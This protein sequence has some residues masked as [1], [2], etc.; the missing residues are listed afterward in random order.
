MSI[1]TKRKKHEIIVISSDEDG[2][3]WRHAPKCQRPNPG[4]NPVSWAPSTAT[5]PPVGQLLTEDA[6]GKMPKSSRDSNLN[7]AASQFVPHVS[8][9]SIFGA[10]TRSS[11]FAKYAEHH[12]P[13]GRTH[14]AARSIDSRSL[15]SPR[16]LRRIVKSASR[17]KRRDSRS[18][19]NACYSSSLKCP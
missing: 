5:N 11:T 10:S 3:E 14:A 7:T 17:W 18:L 15:R 9:N 8:P 4:R 12:I 13:S 19:R 2:P 16:K 6:A 1:G